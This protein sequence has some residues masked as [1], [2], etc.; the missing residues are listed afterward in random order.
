ML[1]ISVILIVKNE[2]AKIKRCLEAVRGFD[3]IVIVD[4]SSTD[5]TVALCRPYTDKIFIVEAKSFC[6]PDRILAVS[7]AQ[8]EWI[9]YIDADEVV[10]PSLK[11]EI[12]SLLDDSPRYNSYYV[13]RKNIFLGRWIRGSGWFPARVLRLFK[14]DAVVFPER[15][16]EDIKPLGEAGM[17]E[18]PLIHYTCENFRAYLEKIRRYTSISAEQAYKKGDRVTA[19]NFLVRLGVLPVLYFFYKLVYKK[20]FIDGFYGVLIASLTFWTVFSTNLKL[21]R[22]GRKS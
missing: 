4:Q 12:D 9:F 10:T 22:L 1:K 3:E 16:H 18:E 2:A 7:K 17:L 11:A 6:E 13:S 8:N 19:L 21:W 14:K 20:G 5:E 15:I